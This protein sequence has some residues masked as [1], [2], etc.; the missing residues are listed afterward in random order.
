[1]PR[2]RIAIS[3]GDA[4]GVGPEI[5]CKACNEP[6]VRDICEPVVLGSPTVLQAVAQRLSLPLPPV[7]D[8][9]G[10]DLTAEAVR[11]GQVDAAC[12][13]AAAAWIRAGIHGCLEG[14]YAA[15]CT[16]PIHK[17]ALAAAGEPYPGHTEMLAAACGLA[18]DDVSMLL[19]A[20]ELSVVLV[21]CH[22]SL[23]SV[24]GSL[25]A[26]RIAQVARQLRQALRRLL[27]REPRLALLGLNPHA[28]EDGLFGDEEARHI[29]P[30]VP[31]LQAEG[32]LIEGPLPPDTAFTAGARRHFDGWV[33]MYHDQALIPFKA[34]AFAEGVNVTLGLPMIRTSVDHG[35]AFDIAWRGEADHGNMIAAIRHAVLLASDRW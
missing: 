24:P 32:V 8:P 33:C 30:V 7:V 17:R 28:G 2:P 13:A 29:A 23:A 21:T 27:R 3:M 31:L 12:G 34:L 26:E 22:Q 1:M 5:C 19:T 35:T 4:A 25:R 14:R 9:A 16:A 10:V 18:A 11:P 6:A 15:L 20:P